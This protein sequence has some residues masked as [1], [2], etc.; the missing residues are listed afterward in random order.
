M[1]ERSVMTETEEAEEMRVYPFA[2]KF[3][4]LE[5]PEFDALV[6]DIR[7]NGLIEPITVSSDHTTIID[8]RNRYWACVE[9][10]VEL[11][12]TCLPADYDEAKILDF[13]VA[14]NLDRRHL[15]AGQKAMLAL[16]YEKLYAAANPRKEEK[17]VAEL[18]QSGRPI[19]GSPSRASERAARVTGA[20]A[21][22]VQQAKAVTRDAPDLAAQVLSGQMAL[23]AA[24][25]R[26]V[27]RPRYLKTKAP[28]K[29]EPKMLTLYTHDGKEVPFPSLKAKQLLT[30]Q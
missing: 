14:K 13:I 12:F 18:R 8:G 23:D 26:T 4:V 6:K 21:R 28:P 20:S 15:N 30:K 2:A 25:E 9:A 17:N 24:Y 7:A 5:G 19:N 22:G 27:Q 10:G 3:P 29:R 16:E 11:T 1:S